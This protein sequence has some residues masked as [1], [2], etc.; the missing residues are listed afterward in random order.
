M[1][2]LARYWFEFEAGPMGIHLPDFVGS[3]YR[4][5]FGQSFR[6]IVC[7]QFNQ[8]C[9]T[10]WGSMN[11]PY[12]MVFKPKQVRENHKW[13]RFSDV[14]RPYVLSLGAVTQTYIAPGEQFKLGVLLV[15]TGI[16]YLPYF[17]HSFE[18]MALHGIGKQRK[19]CKLVSVLGENLVSGQLWQLYNGK[20]QLFKPRMMIYTGTNILKTAEL[21]Q[22]SFVEVRFV[23]PFRLKLDG[24]LTSELHFS[25]LIRS[26]IR[27]VMSMLYFHHGVEVDFE[28]TNLLIEGSKKII[29]YEQDLKWSDWER[30]SSRQDEKM[31]LGGIVGK[32]SFYGDLS[33]F[34]PWLL[35][36]KI[37][38]IGKQTT[39]GL[40]DYRCVWG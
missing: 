12:C 31:K 1:L 11:C 40:G 4:G 15:G 26:I 22:P 9:D 5:A 3:T 30:Y 25:L 39:F 23:T 21:T 27:R 10:C 34:V 36:G 29:I 38:H 13:K 20:D 19:P 14:P 8:D 33:P 18:Q 7:T 35:A 37:L 6:T 17:V 24:K 2:K 32:V 28:T 16:D